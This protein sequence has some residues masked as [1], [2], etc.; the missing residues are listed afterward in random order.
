M[1]KIPAKKRFFRVIKIL[2]QNFLFFPFRIKRLKN[3]LN[4]IYQFEP[5]LTTENEYILDVELENVFSGIQKHKITLKD[6]ESKYGSMTLEEIYNIA[7]LVK[8]INPKSIFEFGTFIGVTTLQMALNSEDET[9]IYT[10]NLSSKEDE[11]MY[12]IGD[13]DEERNLPMLQ[14]GD[15]FKN[16]KQSEKITQLYGDSAVFDYNP[17]ENSIDFILIDASHEYDYVK[18]DT[19]NSFKMLKNGGMLVWHDY[20]NA[21]GVYRY[22]NEIAPKIKIFHIKE[23]HIAFVL[24]FDSNIILD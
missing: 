13:S 7:L 9:K 12:A 18:N 10:L 2:T 19:I 1:E 3:L 4:H 11:T 22:I 5:H 6:I 24:N 8:Q 16:S 15:R 14:P 20:P 23:T 21:P 17:Y